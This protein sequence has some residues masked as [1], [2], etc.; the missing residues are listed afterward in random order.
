MSASRAIGWRDDTKV[1][2]AST[3]SL[4]DK[5]EWRRGRRRSFGEKT[6]FARL[7]RSFLVGGRLLGL[8]SSKI[9][10]GQP[11]KPGTRAHDIA[12]TGPHFDEERLFRIVDAL[13][14]VAQETGKTIPQIA[15]NW[16]LQ[17]DTV[18]NVIIGARNEEQL[19][20]NVGAVG[21]RLNEA[22]IAAL[23]AA[24]DQPPVYP[25]WHQRGFPMLHEAGGA[26]RG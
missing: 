6:H 10:R 8:V 7:C 19:I 23:D 21:W 24:S 15:L 13:E 16:L 14:R 3:L 9:R 11:A 25:A 2:R 12:G 17:R 5:K 22:Q 4:I 18:A 26:S 20:E 1:Y